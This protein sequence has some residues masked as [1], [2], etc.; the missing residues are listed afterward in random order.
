MAYFFYLQGAWDSGLLKHCHLFSALVLQGFITQKHPPTHISFVNSFEHLTES[1]IF[2][3]LRLE[4]KTNND[5]RVNMYAV[6]FQEGD[7]RTKCPRGGQH[8]EYKRQR[9]AST[10]SCKAS[11]QTFCP[12][13]LF[14]L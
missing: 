10:V 4:S 6:E 5:S 11:I 9:T 7:F 14:K 2:N 13:N 3:F 1:K 12:A 8:H